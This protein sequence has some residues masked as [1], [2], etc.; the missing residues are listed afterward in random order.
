MSTPEPL[1]SVVVSLFNFRDLIGPAIESLLA[2]TYRHL[3]IIVVDDGS[4]D[5]GADVVAAM[6]DKRIRLIRQE[7]QGPSGCL[8]RGMREAKGEFLAILSGDDVALP[9]RIERSLAACSQ[10]GVDYVFGAVEFIDHA[11][12][13]ILETSW[14][15]GC[16][17]VLDLSQAE[18]VERL[19]SQGNLLNASTFFCRRSAL[20]EELFRPSLLQLQ[21]YELW[22]RLAARN[23]FVVLEK[24][25]SRYRLREGGTNLS[26]PAF[27]TDLR[28]ANEMFYVLSRAFEG[29]SDELFAKAFD[30]QLVKRPS[31]PLFDREAE[32]VRLLFQRGLSS[33]AVAA[34][35]RLHMLLDKANHERRHRLKDAYGL[36]AALCF[37]MDADHQISISAINHDFSRIVKG[38][39]YYG[40]ETSEAKR[41]SFSYS[42]DT[43]GRFSASVDLRGLPVEGC[44][45][46][47]PW[48]GREFHKIILES[49]VWED[50]AGVA[51][52]IDIAKCPNNAAVSNG[53]N[54]LFATDDPWFV[55][56]RDIGI[57]SLKI[58]G[59]A[60]D[61]SVGEVNLM[62]R[63][64]IIS[65]GAATEEGSLAA[66]FKSFL[67][68]LK[69]KLR[70]SLRLR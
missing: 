40:T 38:A 18:L 61:V 37:K 15:D 59:R 5:G 36:S 27:T 8:N 20:P 17:P 39:V 66:R 54:F 1:V 29:L 48:E 10:P 52:V 14:A 21:D 42:V 65:D 45:R 30:R 23:R 19:F 12:R 64:V 32:E 58:K 6:G 46:L 53:P 25:L 34:S 4:T 24:P 55:I 26:H 33:S 57:R 62:A 68:R 70:S 11:G 50:E 44:L 22:M 35:L 69:S 13:P 47:D 41:Q 2:Q 60:L 56:E 9:D 7:N 51:H 16:F 28:T 67:R 63:S 49:L 3:E 43:F 31:D